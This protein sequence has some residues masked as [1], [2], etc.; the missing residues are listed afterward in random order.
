VRTPDIGPGGVAQLLY[1]GPRIYVAAYMGTSSGVRAPL[2]LIRTIDGARSWSTDADPCGSHTTDAQAVAL[3]AVPGGGLIVVCER[4]DLTAAF[5]RIS[6]DAGATFGPPRAL[7]SGG[8]PVAAGSLDSIVVVGTSGAHDASYVVD[9]S[10]DAGRTWRRTLSAR[11]P[12][13]EASVAFLGF[14]DA[15]TGRVA[16]SGDRLWTTRD[17]GDTWSASRP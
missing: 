15:R 11:V 14:E 10:H 1:D 13:G 5:I 16:F 17:G 6:T 9:V 7:P 12:Q 8:G 3:A 2:R 4:P